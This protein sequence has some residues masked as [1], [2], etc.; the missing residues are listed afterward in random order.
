MLFVPGMSRFAF[1]F[2]IAVTSLALAC[3]KSD[4]APPDPAAGAGACAPGEA[5]CGSFVCDTSTDPGVTDTAGEDGAGAGPPP[6]PATRGASDGTTYVSITFDDTFG[7]QFQIRDV[8][9]ETGVKAT[10]YVNSPRIDEPTYLEGDQIAALA[11]DGH[12][13]AGHTVTHPWLTSVD[14]Q[15]QR[16]QICNDRAALL[17]RGLAVT[18]FAY[19]H[20]A[21]TP[22]T[23]QIARD[24]GYNSARTVGGVDCS[25]C[26]PK[27]DVAPQ[28][29]GTI[30]LFAVHTPPSIKCDATLDSLQKQVTA[31]ESAG[32][33]WVPMVFHHV[34]DGCGKNAVR[35]T[36]FRAFVRWLAA[37]S[38]K[39][40]VKTVAEMVGGPV[41]PPV[42][43]PPPPATP[44][45]GNV[46]QD[47][48]LEDQDSADDQ[49]ARCWIRGGE[50]TSSYQYGRTNDA[51]S[52]QFAL[53]L[54]VKSFTDGARRIL[55]RQD[56]GFCTPTVQA[57]HTYD[58][59]VWYKSD[60]QPRLTVYVRHADGF[61]ENWATSKP[62][63]ASSDWTQ[64]KWTLPPLPDTATGISVGLSLSGNGTV[65]MDDWSLT[66]AAR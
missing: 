37:R 1:G 61:F 2:A 60:A 32:G 57:G 26:P 41:Q 23:Q 19:P 9:A 65:T 13:I 34:C 50:G 58:L 44:A 3:G 35:A 27:L 54:R 5:V 43:V 31:A 20:G 53:F 63:A 66:D 36:T 56:L 62:M 4:D 40:V 6:P 18:S 29:L 46:L 33:G 30:D 64:G 42:T 16:R 8:L 7:D 12:E 10:F 14:E 38:P 24:C 48:G 52:G 11:A 17:A 28:N 45:G 55:S 59:S 51:H 39:T 47:P 22:L 25:N 21:F 15:E 49:M